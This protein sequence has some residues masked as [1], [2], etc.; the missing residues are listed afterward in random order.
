M[1]AV[2]YPIIH[3]RSG[4]TVQVDPEILQYWQ[5]E[6]LNMQWHYSPEGP[7]FQGTQG[8]QVRVA[9]VIL[10]RPAWFSD[11]NIFNVTKAN[12]RPAA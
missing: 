2:A 12:L 3:P 4:V 1:T 10:G 5:E 9:D 11:G 8:R 6:G 7:T